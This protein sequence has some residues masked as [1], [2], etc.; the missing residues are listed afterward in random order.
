MG[1][2]YNNWHL[3]K[4]KR[5]CYCELREESPEILEEQNI[6]QGYCGFCDI[7][8]SPGHLQHAPECHPYSASWCDK[9]LKVQIIVNYAQCI[10]MPLFIGGLFFSKW[11][12]V[13]SVILFI[14]AI[15]I[16]AYGKNLIKS[17]A[18]T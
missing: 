4:E 13:I 7:C 5:N 14:G 9:C 15:L 11:L 17:I 18:G 2:F 1:G 8:G 12:V 3:I 10:S 16:N 6:P